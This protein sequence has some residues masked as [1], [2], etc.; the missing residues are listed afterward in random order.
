MVP[1][2]DSSSTFSQ[3]SLLLDIGGGSTHID[4]SN[5]SKTMQMRSMNLGALVW[6]NQWRAALCCIAAACL[7]D[8][9]C[10]L[11]Q[12]NDQILSYLI[13]LHLYVSCRLAGLLIPCK[14]NGKARVNKNEKKE[15]TLLVFNHTLKAFSSSHSAY[16]TQWPV[17]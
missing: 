8:V 1:S 6:L 10:H 12:S 4:M 11:P 17:S 15:D 2:L 5:L 13:Y 7:G 16:A 3:C 14:I 9:V